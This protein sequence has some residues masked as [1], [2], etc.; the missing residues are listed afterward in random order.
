[1]MPTPCKSFRLKVS[2]TV[3]LNYFLRKGPEDGGLRLEDKI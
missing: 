3:N 1:M 2:C